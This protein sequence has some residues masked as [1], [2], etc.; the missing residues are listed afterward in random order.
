MSIKYAKE[1]DLRP[2]NIKVSFVFGFQDIK[3]YANSVLVV[4]SDDAL[5]RIGSVPNYA[6]ILS[7]AAF[8]GLPARE[9]QRCR[10]WRWSIAEQKRLNI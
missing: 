10:V 7:N 5:V 8:G 6:T 2:F 3:D 1:A 9:I 4:I